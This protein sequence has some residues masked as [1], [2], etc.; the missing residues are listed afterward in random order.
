MRITKQCV[1]VGPGPQAEGQTGVTYAAGISSATAGARGLCLQLAS[2]PPGGRS[3]AHRHD[4][5]ESAAY[6]VEGA[7]VLRFG[8]ALEHE[9]VARA[10]SFLYIPSGVP[11]VVANASDERPAVAVLARTDPDEQE[12]VTELPALDALA[13]TRSGS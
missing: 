8:D 4:E 2:L 3:R 10:G 11:H 1:L 5:H 6:V 7:M 12:S 13:G 9:V